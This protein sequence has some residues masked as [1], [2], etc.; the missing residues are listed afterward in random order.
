MSIKKKRKLRSLDPNLERET[1][2]YGQALPSREFMLQILKEQGVP[3]NEDA[4]RSLLEITEEENE[5]FG[6][7][8]SAMVREGQ[9]MRNRKGDICVVAKLDL[10]KGKVQGHADGFGFLIPDDG[11]ADLF[12][13]S[14]E[15]HK[16]LHGDRVMV[17]E[18][19]V[20]R[21]GRREGAIV[22]VLERAVTQLVGRL[23][24]DHGILFVEAEN[25]RIS[26]DILIPRDESMTASAG[27]V[28]MVEIIRQPSKN[29]QPIGRIV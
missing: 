20:D 5:I 17:R 29:A 8:I 7:R 3:V 9:I 28:V 19:G 25:R 12:L 18:I 22:E 10:V 24:A 1:A 15:M 13:S 4:L 23:H 14:K 6:R 16:A 21:R 27:Q 2:R 26:Q 11:G